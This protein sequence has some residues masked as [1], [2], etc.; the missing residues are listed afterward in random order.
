MNNKITAFCVSAAMLLSSAPVLTAEAADGVI[1]NDTFSDGDLSGYE[2]YDDTASVD[3]VL[4]I[5]SG[6]LRFEESSGWNT[7]NG[8]KKDITDALYA[9]GFTSGSFIEVSADISSSWYDNAAVI[10]IETGGV[11]TNLAKGGPGGET[12]AKATVTG[13]AAV[14]ADGGEPVYL[15]ITQPCGTHLYDNISLTW[16]AAA[17]AS[18]TPD[19]ATAPPSTHSPQ[20][21]PSPDGQLFSYAD[22]DFKNAEVMDRFSVY[23]T[24]DT[25]ARISA[26]GTALILSEMTSAQNLNGF[27][28]DITD[29]VKAAGSGYKYTASLDTESTWWQDNPGS[30]FFEIVTGKETETVPLAEI[31]GEDTD[32][33]YSVSGSGY[34]HFYDSS[35][36]YL[37]YTQLAGYQKYNNITLSYDAGD[38]ATPPPGP[39]PYMPYGEGVTKLTSGRV[40]LGTY[41]PDTARVVYVDDFGSADQLDKYAEYKTAFSSKPG[42]SGG[43]ATFNFSSDWSTENGV[44][45]NVTEAMRESYTGGAFRVALDFRTSYWG[46]APVNVT[47]RYGSDAGGWHSADAASGVDTDTAKLIHV[48]G[49]I[50]GLDNYDAAKDEMIINITQSAGSW[51]IDNVAIELPYDSVKVFDTAVDDWSRLDGISRVAVIYGGKEEGE[52][53]VVWSEPREGSDVVYGTTE[54]NGAVARAIKADSAK[55]ITVN[56]SGITVGDVQIDGQPVT[57]SGTDELVFII[58]SFDNMNLLS[59]PSGTGIY[60]APVSGATELEREMKA[61]DTGDAVRIEGRINDFKNNNECIVIF[62]GGGEPVSVIYAAIGA[63][64]GYQVTLPKPALGAYT[65]V[66]TDTGARTGFT[67][68]SPD[69]FDALRR[70]MVGGSVYELLKSD[71]N[72]IIIGAEYFDIYDTIA[73]SEKRRICD[74]FKTALAAPEITR[75]DAAAALDKLIAANSASADIT[76]ESWR[77]LISDNAP[78]LGIAQLNAFSAFLA[79]SDTEAA[80]VKSRLGKGYTAS[81]AFAATFGACVINA[82]L[83]GAKH[84]S[85]VIDI[86]KANASFLGTDAA[87]VTMSAAKYI[88]SN[89]RPDMLTVSDITSLIERAMSSGNSSLSGGGGGGGG[90]GS[91]SGRE[92]SGSNGSDVATGYVPPKAAE[93]QTAPTAQPQTTVRTFTDINSVGWAKEAIDSL[94]A[95]GVINGY[96]DGTFRPDNNVTREEFVKIIVTAF[97]ITGGSAEF[98]DVAANRWSHGFIAAAAG[99]GIVN[100]TTDGSF[101]PEAPIT[102]QD[103]AVII[104]RT[105][106]SMGKAPAAA[107]TAFSDSDAISEYA[108]DAVGALVSAGVINGTDDNTFD[109]LGNTTRAQAAVMVYRALG[110]R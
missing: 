90:G 40:T 62:D 74:D 63:D 52:T 16:S 89:I 106:Y 30:M 25:S 68:A 82:Q 17:P 86:L 38:M 29:F 80:E 55:K 99:A 14:T 88:M 5:D 103:A 101:M 104:H 9:S 7:R 98:K 3:A 20:T 11:K 96:D 4:S 85:N 13:S 87:A 48:S 8:I 51:T 10:F 110:L 36:V 26:N 44:S 97:G 64:G 56:G 60:A 61:S 21:T 49:V 73:E 75:F 45:V 31:A 95:A 94:L 76:A 72:R 109:P 79:M 66:M 37:C 2:V 91:S 108:K 24:S 69:A 81:D 71:D 93:N 46:G 42:L 28:M 33:T 18:P 50:D 92:L 67:Y 54:L 77:K 100:G 59:E 107:E 43:A 39:T 19:A 22:N 15:C 70:E 6:S 1:I 32:L 34:L 65:A 84:Y 57:A 41:M 58:D 102:R 47:L 78:L 53:G 105:L 27:R 83:C 35:A 12:W 23:D